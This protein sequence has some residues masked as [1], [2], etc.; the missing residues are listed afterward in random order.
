VHAITPI[1]RQNLSDNLALQLKTYIIAQKYQVGERLP[2]VAKLASRFGVGQPTIREAIKKLETA[3]VVSVKHGSGMF[4]GEQVNHLFLPN[5]IVINEPPTKKMLLDLIE[6]KIPIEVQAISDAIAKISDK[7]LDRLEK[8]IKKAEKN[9][10][11][12]DA[13]HE[14]NV[15]FH[16]EIAHASGNYLLFQIIDVLSSLYKK[17]QRFLIDNYMSKKADLE[18]HKRMYRAIKD[19]NKKSAVQLMRQHLAEFRK[20]I[21]HWDPT[22]FNFGVYNEHVSVT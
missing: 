17:E 2:T 10:N 3:G 8:I 16:K 22:K 4:V 5:P 15:L 11:N 19:R 14:L 18:H 20:S 7:E 6:A 9:I 1:K 13:L 21:D 12:D